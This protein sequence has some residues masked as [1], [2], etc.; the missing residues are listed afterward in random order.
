MWKWLRSNFGNWE[1]LNSYGIWVQKCESGNFE[2]I[3]CDIKRIEWNGFKDN[4]RILDW[5][6]D[7]RSIDQMIEKNYQG[8]DEEN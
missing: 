1:I 8:K 7:E 3:N 4:S 2:E 6:D 5:Y